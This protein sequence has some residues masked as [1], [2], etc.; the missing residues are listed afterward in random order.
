MTLDVR[1][2]TL[3]LGDVDL[4]LTKSHSC[5]KGCI[6]M[7]NNEVSIGSKDDPTYACEQDSY[8]AREV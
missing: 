8:K 6:I 2:N 1:R 5:L 4:W 3:Y 7:E